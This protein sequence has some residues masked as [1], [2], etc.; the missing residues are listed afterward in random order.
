MSQT[1]IF[2]DLKTGNQ[3]T[4]EQ[5]EGVINNSFSSKSASGKYYIYSYVKS[6]NTDELK[7]KFVPIESDTK[8]QCCII[9]QNNE[10]YFVT[11]ETA[12]KFLISKLPDEDGE[13]LC[14]IN[15]ASADGKSKL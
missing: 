3:Y 15:W 9:N 14:W 12:R 4:R 2:G 10:E 13:Y 6:V 1:F 8:N 5:Y 7:E 11:K